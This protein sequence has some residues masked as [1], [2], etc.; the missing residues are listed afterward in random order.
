MNLQQE[1]RSELQRLRAEIAVLKSELHQ[2][3]SRLLQLEKLTGDHTD[4]YPAM[5]SGLGFPG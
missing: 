4:Q 3:E 1:F 5:P 2:K